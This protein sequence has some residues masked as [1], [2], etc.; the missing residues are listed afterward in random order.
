[1]TQDDVF[2]I[3]NNRG[4]FG[5]QIGF[6][7]NSD[8]STLFEEKHGAQDPALARLLMG[9]NVNVP[10]NRF[11]GTIVIHGASIAFKLIDG[12]KLHASN[13]VQRKSSGIP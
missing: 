9:S 3:L 13:A 12:L 7:A 4:I 11:Y 2:K 5:C 10:G 8:Y 1:M 6:P